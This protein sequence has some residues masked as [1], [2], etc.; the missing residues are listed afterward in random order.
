MSTYGYN[1]RKWTA[2]LTDTFSNSLGFP[3]LTR[4]LTVTGLLLSW[5][6]PKPLIEKIGFKSKT[7]ESENDFD[8]KNW[9]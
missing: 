2:L 5:C 3:R 8:Q 4:E 7:K 1:S 6:R 9:F